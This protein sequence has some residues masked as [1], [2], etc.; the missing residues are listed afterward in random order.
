MLY[1]KKSQPAP[2]CLEVEQQKA[3]GDYK[4]GCVIEQ[5]KTDFFNKC[6]ICEDAQLSNINVEHFKAH[7]DDKTLMFAW[8]N[9]FF[10]CAHCNNTKS[11][12]FEPLLDCTNKEDIINNQIDYLFLPYPNEKVNIATHS[13]ESKVIN[14]TQLLMAVFNGTTTL[15]TIESDNLREKLLDEMCDFQ[16]YLKKYYRSYNKEDKQKYAK[17]IIRHLDKSSAFTSF[18]RQVIKCD[19]KFYHDFVNYCSI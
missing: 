12:K 4:C 17:K 2:E 11:D 7:R 3:N 13:Q 16:K 10:A 6:Y 18:K 5:L 15:K 14:T 8:H 19:E 9:L 1:F